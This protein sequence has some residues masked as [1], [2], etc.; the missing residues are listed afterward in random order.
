MNHKAKTVVIKV[1]KNVKTKPTVLDLFCGCGGLTK[2]LVNA[3]LDVIAGIDHFE[4]AVQSY[5]KNF[6]HLAICKDLTTYSPSMFSKAHNVG[7]GDVD[8]L[9]GGPPC[10]GF[11]QAGRRDQN[12]PRNSL[13]KEYVKYLEFFKPKAFLMENVL[14]IL[15]MK[16]ANGVK[17]IDIIM[18]ELNKNYNTIIC[19]LYA[20]D[21]EVPQ[22]RRR[23]II[24][25][26]RKDLGIVPTEP[27]TVCTLEQ[28]KPV[29]SILVS[30]NEADKKLFL[31]EKAILGIK[32]KKEKSK[33]KGHGFGAQF[34]DLEKPAFTV[35]ARAWKDGY[36]NLMKYND[37]EIRRMSVL[38]LKRIQSFPDDFILEGSRKDVI[39]QIGNAVPCKFAYWL[40]KHLLN[41][42]QMPIASKNPS[43]S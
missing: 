28:R 10:Q 12:D 41:T 42:L 22:N 6:N 40:G 25:G 21:F 19:K 38:E 13:F 33:A 34:L 2:G 1:K 32:K 36:E 23:V 26:V 20:S 17:A 4:R 35:P 8:I 9:V 11:S 30:K 18:A 24:I 15:S 3:G 7:K 16:M 31:S 14:G 37:K 39:I 27:K 5:D 43:S 29:K